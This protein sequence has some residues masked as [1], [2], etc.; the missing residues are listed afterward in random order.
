MVIGTPLCT[1]QLSSIWVISAYCYFCAIAPDDRPRPYACAFAYLYI[2]HYICFFADKRR[3][4]YL[5]C[6]ASKGFY[7]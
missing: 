2:S 1:V 7:H 6:L 5:G 3:L 4:M